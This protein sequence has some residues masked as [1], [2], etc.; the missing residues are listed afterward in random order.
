LW[1]LCD[2]FLAPIPCTG[3]VSH[4]AQNAMKLQGSV[5]REPGRGHERQ[6]QTSSFSNRARRR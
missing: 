4:K 2:W 6:A 1:G 5:L 3:H